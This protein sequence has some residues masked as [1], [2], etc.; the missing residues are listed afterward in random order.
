MMDS[1]DPIN[2]YDAPRTATANCLSATDH[3]DPLVSIQLAARSV[4]A[5]PRNLQSYLALS[6]ALHR[7]GRHANS[8]DLVQRI[9][10][11][12]PDSHR[13]HSALRLVDILAM[14]AEGERVEAAAEMELER[15]QIALL[16]TLSSGRLGDN[17]HERLL[18]EVLAG[19][20]DKLLI[21]QPASP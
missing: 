12:I 1:L 10:N 2:P 17:W 11:Q 13:L 7:A 6:L 18:I 9:I 4:T 20:V 21:E 14:I 5:N 8:R 3:G 16:A 15:A 19:E